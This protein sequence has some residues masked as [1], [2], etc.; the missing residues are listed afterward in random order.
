MIELQSVYKSYY[1]EKVAIPVLKGVSLCIEE[2]EFVALMGPSGSGKSTLLNI[3][4]CLDQADSGSYLFGATDISR[5]DDDHLTKLRNE[6]LGFVFQL[7]NLIPRISARRNVELPMLYRGVAKRK[8]LSRTQEALEKMGLVEWADHSPAELSGGQQQRVAIARAL[9][10]DPQLII[11]DEPTGSLDTT[12]GNE[13]MTL[14]QELHQSGTTI[15]LVTHEHEVANYAQR[16][17][18]LRDGLVV[19]G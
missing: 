17:I 14:F 12:T 18:H 19:D 1:R 8:R 4:G 6:K 13:I 5:L 15:L 9:V 3:I 7:F 2:S 11:A 16:T 10:N